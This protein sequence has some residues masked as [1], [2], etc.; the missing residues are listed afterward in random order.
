MGRKRILDDEKKNRLSIS[1]SIRNISK[2]K[3]MENYSQIVENLITQYFE[4][5]EKGSKK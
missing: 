2:L 1:L 5:L 3:L 4:I